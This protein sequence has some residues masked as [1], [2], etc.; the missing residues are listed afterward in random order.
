MGFPKAPLKRIALLEPS[1]ASEC[2]VTEMMGQIRVGAPFL[3]GFLARAGFEARVFAEELT[4]FDSKFVRRIADEFDA[5]GLSL[6]INTLPRGLKLA[7]ALKKIRPDIPVVAGGPSTSAYADKLLAACDAVMKGRAEVTL[8]RLFQTNPSEWPEADIPGLITGAGGILKRNVKTTPVADEL[9]SYDLVEHLGPFTHREGI[10]GYRKPAVYSLFASTGCVRSCRFCK[11]EKRFL[12]RS[13][14]NVIGDLKALLRIHDRPSLARFMLV[15]DCLFADLD[16]T[17]ELLR[18]IEHATRGHE[19]SFSAQFHV[20]PTADHELMDLFRKARFTSL[21]IGFESVSQ[22][23]LDHERKGTTVSDNDLAIEQCRKFDI[24]PYGY[25]IV[26]FDTDTPETVSR[27]FQYIMDRKIIA[28]VLPVGIMNRDEDG[29]P[30]PEADR[31]LSDTSFGATVFV[32]HRP[33]Q[34]T[35]TQL[36]T[37]INRGYDRITS[38]KRIRDFRTRYERQFLFGFNRCFHLWN[39]AMESHVAFLL[40]HAEG[41][42]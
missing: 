35:A 19:V 26:G 28:Q 8:P 3:A 18:R 12:P 23:S 30:T 14:S 13:M 36:Q 20:Q 5:V 11:S 31:V 16:W 10:F 1:V 9:T 21:A 42:G 37:M 24:V 32:S 29:N 39:P 27:V 6:A 38:L 22:A 15:D 17:K 41:N 2:V 25:F 33:T 40:N 34:M 4:E 7:R